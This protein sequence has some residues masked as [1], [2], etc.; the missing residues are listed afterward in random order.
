MTDSTEMLRMNIQHYEGLL[1]LA[2]EHPSGN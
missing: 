2:H 1:R